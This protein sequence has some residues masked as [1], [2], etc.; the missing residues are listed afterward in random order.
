M[1]KHNDAAEALEVRISGSV[2][3]IVFECDTPQS[4][5]S[6]F[7]SLNDQVQAG[8]LHLYMQ[9]LPTSINGKP[10]VRQ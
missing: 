1:S 5:Q 6:I 9:G 7:S 2:V 8:F 3:T 4:A 10:V